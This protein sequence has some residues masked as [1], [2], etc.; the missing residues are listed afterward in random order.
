VKRLDIQVLFELAE[1]FSGLMARLNQEKGPSFEYYV[2][3]F[4]METKLKAF[5][6]A[7]GAFPLSRDSAKEALPKIATGIRLFFEDDERTKLKQDLAQEMN[8]WIFWETKNA[9]QEFR[10]VFSAECRNSETYFMEKKVGFD[11]S[12]LLHSAEE[13]LHESIRPSVPK[14]ALDEL[15]EAGRCLALESYTASGFHT[16]RGLEVM[17]AAYYKA[18]SG[19][20]KEF[21]SWFDYVEALEEL[22]SDDSSPQKHPS[23]KVAAMLD[24]M[25]QLDRNPLMHPSD[26]LDEVGADSLFKLGIVT[27]TELAKDMRDMANQPELKLVTS[28][29]QQERPKKEV[30]TTVI[31]PKRDKKSDGR[32]GTDEA[33]A[34]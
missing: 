6:N 20:S 18:V 22:A 28:N 34:S 17:M 4:Q 15:R 1:T 7:Q 27:I 14:L 31:R 11:I 8:S 19:N 33:E 16:L 21:K 12:T 13:N 32:A 10:H 5:I 23:S 25:R 3:L 24:R 2:V 30:Q 29:V 26:T 9:L